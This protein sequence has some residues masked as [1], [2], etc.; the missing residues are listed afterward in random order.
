[1]HHALRHRQ[2][3]GA[4]INDQQQ[5]A[6]GVHRCPYPGGRALETL[7][8]LVLAELTVFDVPQHGIQLIELHLLDVHITRKSHEKARR[9]SAAS[10]SQCNTVF[11]STSK[12][13]AV[14]RMPKPSAKHANMRTISPTA[15]RLPWK[16]VPCVSRKYPL[17]ER[18]YNWRHGPPLGWPL[19]RR[20][21]NPSQP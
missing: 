10:T 6:L 12:T 19:A 5:F 11:G 4:D 20:L 3:P 9:C 15:T 13:R 2:G 17:Q 14:A 7:D 1:M 18:Q 8:R 16:I 21:P